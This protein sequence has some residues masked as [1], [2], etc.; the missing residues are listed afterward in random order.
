MEEGCQ[1]AVR[2][3]LLCFFDTFEIHQSFAGS[4]KQII[5]TLA[6]DDTAN[7]WPA[8]DPMGGEGRERVGRG[9]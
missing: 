5:T 3:V 1:A 9:G 6:P 2:A 4:K 7:F 8:A